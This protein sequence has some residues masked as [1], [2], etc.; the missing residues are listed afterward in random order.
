MGTGTIIFVLVVLIGIVLPIVLL[1]SK[2]KNKEKQFIKTLFD[3]AEKNNCK[4]SEHN[5]WNNTLIG[6]DKETRKLFFIR[7]TDNNLTTNE[8]DLSEIQKCRIVK[9]NRIVNNKDSENNVVDKLE[10]SFAFRDTKKSETILEFYNT[11]RDN[12]TVYRELQLIEKWS[13]LVN[14]TIAVI[15]QKK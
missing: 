6:I 15:N 13:E 1:N 5:L 11:N 12:L 3:L 10:L 14:A 2:K 9:S 8:I 4:I 7:K